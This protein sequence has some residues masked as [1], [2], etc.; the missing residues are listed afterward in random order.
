M[1][2]NQSRDRHADLRMAC[3]GPVGGLLRHCGENIPSASQP[4]RMP[5]RLWCTLQNIRGAETAIVWL[6]A[7]HK[8]SDSPLLSPRGRIIGKW[9][10]FHFFR[11]GT[12]N[13]Y[14]ELCSQIQVCHMCCL[15]LQPHWCI[16][17]KQVQIKDMSSSITL[18]HICYFLNVSSRHLGSFFLDHDEYNNAHTATSLHLH[19]PSK[20]NTTCP[21][22]PNE[23][24]G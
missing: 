17:L 2:S 16:S 23:A 13:L 18:T 9:K 4:I 5:W 20:T 10:A 6:L 19:R 3:S 15:S 1:L 8:H 22:Q 24:T 11:A 21:V 14:F 12:M 7:A